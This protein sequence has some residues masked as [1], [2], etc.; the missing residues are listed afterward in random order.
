MYHADDQT[1]FLSKQ[2]LRPIFIVAVAMCASLSSAFAN[3]TVLMW[4]MP[5]KKIEFP[6]YVY[7]H[8]KQIDY[9]YGPTQQAIIGDYSSST[10][11]TYELYYGTTNTPESN[12]TIAVQELFD[13]FSCKLV[14]S[15]GKIDTKNTTCPGAAIN[16][17]AVSGSSSS[18]VYTVTMGAIAW[19]SSLPP[20]NTPV[21]TDYG[22]REITFK[23][24]TRYHMIRVGQVCTKSDNPNNLS[25]CQTTQNLFEIKK[26][27][28]DTFT[29]D[30]A[31]EEGTH[32]PA[33]LKSYAFTVTAY[34]KTS[35]DAVVETGGY[36]G[37]LPYATKVELTSMPVNTS[38]GYQAPQ[39]ATNVDISA[40]DGYNIS[41]KGYPSAP[42]Y[43]TYTVPPENSNLLGAAE[44]SQTT[45]LAQISA[46]QRVCKTSSQ[47]PSGSTA[48]AWDLQRNDTA[49][50][51]Q[52][53]MSPCTYAKAKSS[54]D[55]D[56]FCCLGAYD[57]PGTCDQAA[58]VLGANNST[59]VSNLVAPVSNRVYRFAY[60]DAIGDF[61]CPAETDFIIEFTSS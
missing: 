33:G 58:G 39:G 43:C 38:E 57:T 8:G 51:Y 3:D 60:D 50:N 10:N 25:K 48:T 28:S 26:G 34:Q 36:D 46:G 17:P 52:G 44:Y 16:A 6:V 12:R 19:P 22:K 9:L 14:L 49:G 31:K 7:Q 32:F 59:Y 5:S 18:N 4:Q 13:W 11:G 15:D 2:I 29:V 47:L 61:A 21:A 40:V 37:G 41:A 45:P 55:V 23:N 27:E 20:T 24:E 1:G 53:C 54:D 56:L 35:K 42:T 30:N